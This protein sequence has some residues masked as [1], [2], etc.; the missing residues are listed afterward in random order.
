MLSYCPHCYSSNSIINLSEWRLK[1]PLVVKIGCYFCFKAASGLHHVTAPFLTPAHPPSAL[2]YANGDK[3][4]KAARKRKLKMPVTVADERERELNGL[5]P[6]GSSYLT[7][8]YSS[9][10]ATAPSS[11]H[12]LSPV[13]H[14]L[15][16]SYSNANHTLETS[17]AEKSC[18]IKAL[19][20]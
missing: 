15:A 14:Y 10:V 16:T 18:K 19:T 6:V 7:P 11:D 17:L 4:T 20:H 2:N 1:L 9:A 13:S 8:Q 5:T 3:K 12:K